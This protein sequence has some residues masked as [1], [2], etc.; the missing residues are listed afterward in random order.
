MEFQT[1][2]CTFPGCPAASW[3]DDDK[4]SKDFLTLINSTGR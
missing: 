2:V 4:S 3:S 1:A